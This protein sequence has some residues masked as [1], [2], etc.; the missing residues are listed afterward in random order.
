L[1]ARW[2]KLVVATVVGDW[3][4]TR[5]GGWLWQE[6]CR[7][8]PKTEQNRER[9]D[10]TANGSRGTSELNGCGGVVQRLDWVATKGRPLAADD[11]SERGRG[12]VGLGMTE[13]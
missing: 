1:G 2:R 5:G 9:D 3:T 6:G 10:R 12:L 7:T 11:G 8:K 13:S 4:A